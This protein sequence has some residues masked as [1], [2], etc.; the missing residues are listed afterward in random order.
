MTTQLTRPVSPTSVEPGR[1]R[2]MALAEVGSFDLSMYDSAGQAAVAARA[3]GFFTG[4]D[5]TTQVRLLAL[6]RP[7]S[8]DPAIR[9]IQDLR[10]ACPPDEDW[11]YAGLGGVQT[12]L[13]TLV[14]M[15]D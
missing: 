3:G 1:E 10:R 9:Y 7:F 13:E 14:R 6:S 2:P 12:F 5:G 4:L 11:K 15:A 8:A